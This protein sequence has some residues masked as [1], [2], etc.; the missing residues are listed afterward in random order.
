MSIHV[1]YN[2]EKTI[3]VTYDDTNERIYFREFQCPDCKKWTSEDEVVW[4]T[5]EGI[6]TMQDERA[7][8]YC[9]SCCPCRPEFIEL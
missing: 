9:V 7:L 2:A 8:P 3:R 1:G 5:P 4:T 6:V